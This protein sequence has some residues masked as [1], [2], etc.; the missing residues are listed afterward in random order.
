MTKVSKGKN[1]FLFEN[2]T[3]PGIGLV[4]DFLAKHRKME[5]P[6]PTPSNRLIVWNTAEE[7]QLL[8]DLARRVESSDPD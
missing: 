4:N 2:L 7:K 3:A 6:S 1:G 5:R 8:V